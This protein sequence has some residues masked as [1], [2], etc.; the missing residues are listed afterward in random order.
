VRLHGNDTRDG[1][2]GSFPKSELSNQ[3]LLNFPGQSWP[4]VYIG[5][6]LST[7][8]RPGLPAGGY[9]QSAALAL[10]SPGPVL[11][12]S[13]RGCERSKSQRGRVSISLWEHLHDN[14]WRSPGVSHDGPTGRIWA[15]SDR[16]ANPSRTT[17]GKKARRSGWPVKALSGDSV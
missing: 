3:L 13:N 8:L 10:G 7:E 17:G 2:N 12:P 1:E 6:K 16:W 11:T 14:G 9:Q 15:L 5:C 4:L